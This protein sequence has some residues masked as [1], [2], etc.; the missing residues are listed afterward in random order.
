MTHDSTS[1]IPRGF[2]PSGP[3]YEEEVEASWWESVSRCEDAADFEPSELLHERLEALAQSACET[4][5][6]TS[7]RARTL[8]AMTRAT[9]AML[10]P[11]S[12]DEPFTPAIIFNGSRTVVPSD[13]EEDELTLLSQAL[14]LVEPVVL[15]ARIADVVWTYQFP[16]DPAAALIATDA[17]L[18]VP[19]TWDAWIRSGRDGYRRAVELSRRQGK[20]GAATLQK[21]SATLI[22][23]LTGEAGPGFLQAQV[24]EVLRTTRHTTEGQ[25]HAL[26]E[27]IRDLA[28]QTPKGTRRERA[29]LREA[30]AWWCRGRRVDEAYACQ[31]RI[32]DSYAIEAEAQIAGD[33][34]ALVASGP[35]EQSIEVLRALPR[36]YRDANGLELVLAKRQERLRELREY[37]LEEMTP[38]RRGEIEIHDIVRNARNRVS[39]LDR[40]AALLALSQIAPLFN[41]AEQTVSAREDLAGG[42]LRLMT[43]STLSSDARKV[44]V[45]A[46][47]AASGPSERELLDELVRRNT[48]RI[49]LAVQALIAPA[50]EALTNEHRFDFAFV[51]AVCRESATVPM[52]HAGL[53]ARGLWHGL[54]GDYPSA[55]SLLIPQIENMLRIRLKTQG[56]HTLYIGDRGVE[57]EKALGALLDMNESTTFLGPDLAFELRAVLLEQVGPNL[58]NELAHGLVTDGGMRSAPSVYTWWLCLRMVLMPYPLYDADEDTDGD[59]VPRRI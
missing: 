20:P 53:W 19:L 7:L 10:N 9:S 39:G 27:R 37:S 59:A 52:R 56:V 32:A 40:P 44:S 15:R 57:S 38:V 16:R 46:G 1:S 28:A 36:K 23:F 58:R 30:S 21:V 2:E 3:E 35:L 43:R 54:N 41:L 42:L 24:S 8:T 12:W 6:A 26:G 17:Y 4:E 47:D 5:G 18:A 48:P 50:I 11:D 49:G 13:L 31:V 33:R 29:L 45:S 55:V 25:A 34:P 14:L 51:E 22:E